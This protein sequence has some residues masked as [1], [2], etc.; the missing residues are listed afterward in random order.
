MQ[1]F[2][3]RSPGCSMIKI[4]EVRRI[5]TLGIRISRWLDERRAR[6]HV[7]G[8]HLFALLY[9]AKL[10]PS[11]CTVGN[12]S[13]SKHRY[14]LRSTERRPT[15]NQSD[16]ARRVSHGFPF[17]C[18][19]WRVRIAAPHG[20]LHTGNVPHSYSCTRLLSPVVSCCCCCTLLDTPLLVTRK[21]RNQ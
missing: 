5:F 2:Y 9:A 17:R 19:K 21:T 14:A 1:Q 11:A 6:G 10:Y 20:D 8:A 18:E 16:F 13:R 4:T 12:G 3:D 15:Q 7:T